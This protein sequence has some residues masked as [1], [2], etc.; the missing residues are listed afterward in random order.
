MVPNLSCSSINAALIDE[1]DENRISSGYPVDIEL[2]FLSRFTILLFS[3]LSKLFLAPI[4]GVYDKRKNG[5]C[6][7]DA[8]SF[9]QNRRHFFM[10]HGVL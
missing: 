2:A 1:N 9:G 4:E 10:I 8:E 3:H 7:L 6:D 5:C